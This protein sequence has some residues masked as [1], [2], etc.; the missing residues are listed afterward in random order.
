MDQAGRLAAALDCQDFEH[1]D[2]TQWRVQQ[3]KKARPL[4]ARS[5]M[6]TPKNLSP[7]KRKL[8]AGVV[9]L[10]AFGGVGF[11]AFTSPWLW[12]A[13]HPARDVADG[14]PAN[15]ENGKLM[16]IAGDCATCH[17]TTNQKD[18]L[19]LGGG[20]SFDTAFGRFYMPNISPDPKDGIGNWTLAQFTKAVREGVGPADVMPDG[21]NLYPAFP[22]TSYQRMSAN[23]VRDMFAYIKTLEPLPGKA[24]D[25]DLKFPYS[26]RR[27][28]GVWRLAFLDGRP[29][30]NQSVATKPATNA[31]AQHELVAR[32]RYLVE[33]AGHCA[34]CHSPRAFTG[35]IKAGMHYGGGP[36]PDGKGYFPNISQDETGI[37]FWA[38]NSV[39]NYLKS[40]ISPL[41]KTAGGDMAEVIAN[42]SQLPIN[43][44]RAMAAYLKT[45][46]GVDKP[47]PGQPE[48]NLTPQIVMIPLQQHNVVLPISDATAVGKADS[49]Y[50]V[51]TK[52]FHLDEAGFGTKGGEAGKLL[53]TA[54]LKVLERKNNL[55]KVKLE[56]WQ[57]DGVQS[58]I[59]GMQGQRMMVGVLDEAAIEKLERGQ[60]VASQ[61]GPAWSPVSLTVWIDNT[62]LN[63][64]LA[65][66]W[67]Y[68]SSL[69]NSSCG[70]CHSLPEP[71]HYLANQWI[72]N[73]GA[74]RRYT[75]LTTDQYRLL[76]GYL[77][78]HA[79][80]VHA[81]EAS[82]K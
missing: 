75:S 64:G 1:D 14:G 46:P 59:F 77:Q 41:N 55:L 19:K 61:S 73:L 20:R 24:P 8:V 78:N 39:V 33:A 56:G 30:E 44:L 13:T 6:P 82:A 69:Y 81:A 7:K 71:H 58:A 28:I 70:T 32:G 40:G 66:M 23:D 31:S 2:E 11:F 79:Q 67:S 42:T 36:T 47:A 3:P 63:T 21:K 51:N 74:M 45:A 29:I 68:S 43:E 80:D 9:G 53:A 60:K 15:L 22:Y 76:L 27:G 72:G 62:G 12:S 35:A 50:V 26:L 5:E 65:D 17:A 16:F 25:H 18:H 34:E 57:V 10:A 49:V 54:R 52:P 4:R 38:A 37:K 48:P